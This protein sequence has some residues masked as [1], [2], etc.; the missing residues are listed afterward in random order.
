MKKQENRTEKTATTGRKNNDKKAR[1]AE[2]SKNQVIY[3]I[4]IVRVRSE[5]R[6]REREERSDENC[7]C[8]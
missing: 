8:L 7:R 1:H 5:I 2:Q 3:Y 6:Q 4:T